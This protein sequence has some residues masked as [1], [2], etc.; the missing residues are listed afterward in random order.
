MKDYTD[1]HEALDTALFALATVELEFYPRLSKDENLALL[2]SFDREELDMGLA[3]LTSLYI[4]TLTDE[5]MSR[6]EIITHLAYDSLMRN[7]PHNVVKKTEEFFLN[8][9]VNPKRSHEIEAE[10]G[11][12]D[13]TLGLN[14]FALSAVD[15]CVKTVGGDRRTSVELMRSLLLRTMAVV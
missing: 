3:L 2:E 10:L 14:H 6:D 7:L 11:F 15:F 13:F 5:T 9:K 4:D 12:I 1:R 8:F